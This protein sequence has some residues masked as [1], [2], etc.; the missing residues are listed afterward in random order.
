[1]SGKDKIVRTRIAPSPTGNLHIGTVRTALYNLLFAR[2]MGGHFYFRLEDTDVERSKEEYTKEIIEGFKFLGIEWDVPLVDEANLKLTVD[3]HGIV[4]QS[5]RNLA[6]RDYIDKLIATGKAYKC[7]ATPQELDEMRKAQREQKLPEGYDNRGRLYSEDEIKRYEQE[8][9]NYV[10]RLNL[11]EDRDIKW[12]DTVRGEMS[13]NTK[14]LGGDPVI[15]KSSGQILYN[16]AVVVDDA[17]MGVTHVFR[18]EDHLTNTAKQIA[19]YEAFGFDVPIFGHLPLIFTKNREKL[20]KRK[21]GDIAGV[22]KYVR[23]GYL[24]EAL[25]NYLVA[26]SYTCPSGQEVYDLVHGKTYF[27]MSALSKSPAVYDLDKLNW[28]NREYIAKFS[29]VEL[30]EKLKPFLRYDLSKFAEADRRELIEAIRGNLNKLADI[31]DNISYFFEEPVITDDL[32][33]SLEEGR[34]LLKCLEERIEA[35]NF[36]FNSAEQMKNEINKIGEEKGMKGK[37]LFWP[38][39]IAISG[40]THGP[41]LGLI[42]KL[43]GK[44]TVLKRL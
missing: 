11:G 20:S 26:T 14:D 2:K 39:R 18:G 1:M 35:G 5:T 25:N 3:E 37:K 21:H 23:E 7:F 32:K 33:P 30:M 38:I 6:H 36:D 13:I 24:P 9:R 15:M 41:D 42:M 16:F 29:Y 44:E 27:D 28:Y 8:G 43:L 34:D 17:D 19:I 40:R 22:E 12:T 31:N 4:R 10:V